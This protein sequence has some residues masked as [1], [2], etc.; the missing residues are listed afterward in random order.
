VAGLVARVAEQEGQIKALQA[1]VRDLRERN[2]KLSTDTAN[3]LTKLERDDDA[4]RREWVEDLP[5]RTR[6]T[7]RVTYRPREAHAEAEGEAP[8]LASVAEQTLANV[9]APGGRK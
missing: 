6:H 9:P 1:E 2:V 3:R 7:T 4:K 8:S 5:A